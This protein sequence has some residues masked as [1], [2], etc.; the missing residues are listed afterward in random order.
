M[1]MFTFSSTHAKTRIEKLASTV[2][3]WEIVHMSSGLVLLILNKSLRS[4]LTSK[5]MPLFTR[6]QTAH[7]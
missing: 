4:K 1:V 3:Y 2:L 5:Q 7:D 6:T